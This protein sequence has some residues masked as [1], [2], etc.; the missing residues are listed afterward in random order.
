MKGNG[1]L[2]DPAALPRYALHRAQPMSECFERDKNVIPAEKRT[3][4]LRVSIP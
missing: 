4:F 2:P 1:Q 3:P